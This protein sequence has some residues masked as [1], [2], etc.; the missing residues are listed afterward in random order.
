MR[1]H[2]RVCKCHDLQNGQTHGEDNRHRDFIVWLCSVRKINI[3]INDIRIIAESLS[4]VQQK[5]SS[6][7]KKKGRRQEIKTLVYVSSFLVSPSLEEI[8]A[9]IRFVNNSRL[10]SLCTYFFE[11]IQITSRSDASSGYL[12]KI[13]LVSPRWRAHGHSARSRAIFL[14]KSYD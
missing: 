14:S 3:R 5:T 2:P 8:R 11:Q 7:E 4:A 9:L 12:S 6:S 1:G 13:S 10:R